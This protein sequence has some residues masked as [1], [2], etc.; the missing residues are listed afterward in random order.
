LISVHRALDAAEIEH[1]IGG[2]VALAVHAEPRF[3]ADIDLNVMADPQDPGSLLGCLPS[4]LDIHRSAAREI[5]RDGQTR[6]M[7][8]NPATPLDLFLPQHPSYHQLVNDR[9]VLW[10]FAGVEIKVMTA[11]DLMV[12]KML[13]DRAKDWVDIESLLEVGAGDPQEAAHWIRQF[14]GA[15]D[16]RLTRLEELIR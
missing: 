9:A 13:F 16:H 14:L 6:L 3:T 4:D 10:D 5:E 8:R 11:T 1:C 2:A 15:E 12:F 7:W